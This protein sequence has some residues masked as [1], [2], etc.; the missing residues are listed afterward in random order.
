MSFYKAQDFVEEILSY[1]KFSFDRKEISLELNQHMVDKIEHY[2]EKGYDEKEAEN[3]AINHMGDPK[4]IGVQLNKEHNPI[5]GWIWA[6]TNIGVRI[7]ITISIFILAINI[8]I[9]IFNGS[10]VK[11]IAEEN[12]VYRL[13]INERVEIDNRV[14][15]FTN[16]IYEKNGDMNIFYKDYEKSLF[17]RSDSFDWI[18]HI[19][20]DLGNEY[21]YKARSTSGGIVSKSRRVINDFSQDANYLIIN[22]NEYNREYTVEIP[23]KIGGRDE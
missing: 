6:I 13:D 18:G 4:E 22:Y 11:G 14:I 1:V 21:G 12:I 16:L 7:L 23:L 3:L 8:L 2:M 17:G 5:L 20:D 10:G 9:V 15:E 19:K